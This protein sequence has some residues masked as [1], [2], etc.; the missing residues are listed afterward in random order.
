MM[1]TSGLTLIELMVTLAVIAILAS[2]AVPGF[3]TYT[4]NN[5]QITQINALVASLNFARSEATK[6]GLPVAMCTS[7][8]G[9]SCTNGN[10][11]DGWLVFVNADNDS[12][13]AVSAG[14]ELLRI[15]GK[16]GGGHTLR[17][18]TVVASAVT[19]SPRGFASGT[20]VFTLC[21][22]RGASQARQVEIALTGRVSSVNNSPS[23]P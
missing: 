13:P 23:C 2:V 5:R 15:T 14:D 21:D 19:F 4:A 11:E 16:L 6:R 8:N 12:P 10:W 1:K 20:G 17:G 9:S 7:S 18:D 22:S 3:Q